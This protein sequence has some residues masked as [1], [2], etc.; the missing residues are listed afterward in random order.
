MPLREDWHE[1]GLPMMRFTPFESLD[2][3]ARA[4]AMEA[5]APFLIAALKMRQDT[6]IGGEI[7]VNLPDGVTTIP[8][9]GFMSAETPRE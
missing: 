1:A 4:T 7:L 2:P 3:I 9:S 6:V 5:A 8:A